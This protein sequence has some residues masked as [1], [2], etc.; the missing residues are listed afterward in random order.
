MAN[1]ENI[2]RIHDITTYQFRRLI[3]NLGLVND[4]EVRGVVSNL[5][6]NQLEGTIPYCLIPF[7]TANTALGLLLIPLNNDY[8]A[9]GYITR[10]KIEL[11]DIVS[12]GN[13]RVKDTLKHYGFIV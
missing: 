10:G 13:Y 8:M 11:S 7:N 5:I 9:F 3:N 6:T 1:K 2:K 12:K 4:D